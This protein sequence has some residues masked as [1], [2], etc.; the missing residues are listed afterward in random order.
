MIYEESQI[1]IFNLLNM[2]YYNIYI[3]WVMSWKIFQIHKRALNNYYGQHV[4]TLREISV[5]IKYQK[6]NEVTIVTLSPLT[7]F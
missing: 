3:Y 1:Q 7:L 6:T 5:L 4:L 2:L